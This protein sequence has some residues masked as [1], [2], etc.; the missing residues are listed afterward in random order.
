MNSWDLNG[1]G[2]DT[3]GGNSLPKLQ[4]YH[5]L[6]TTPLVTDGTDLHVNKAI[7]QR[8]IAN[9]ILIQVGRY[10]CAFFVPGYPD[11]DARVPCPPGG[12]SWEETSYEGFQHPN[13]NYQQVFHRNSHPFHVRLRCRR[14]H[15]LAHPL[16][17]KVIH[18]CGKIKFFKF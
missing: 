13:D 5:E 18:S 15:L 10:A 16:C 14:S 9:N 8:V 1:W 12:Q 11:H 4:R 7:G 3:R 2:T 17:V 6:E